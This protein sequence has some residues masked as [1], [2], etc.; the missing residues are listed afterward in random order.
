M[1][2]RSTSKKNPVFFGFSGAFQKIIFLG[3]MGLP[4]SAEASFGSTG[5]QMQWANG[6]PFTL[7]IIYQVTTWPCRKAALPARADFVQPRHEP[8]YSARLSP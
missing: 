5:R 8:I 2:A 3:F 1:Q 6:G 7:S 4:S